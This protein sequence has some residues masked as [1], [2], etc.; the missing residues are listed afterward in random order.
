[1]TTPAAVQDRPMAGA[2]DD[3][4]FRLLHI[5]TVPMSLVFLRGQLAYMQARGADIHL[6]SSP[7]PALDS[8]AAEHGVPA[9][10]VVMNRRISPIADLAA[11]A[12]L[13]AVIRKLKPDIVHAHTPKAGLLGMIAAA[14]ERVPVRIYHMRGL[15]MLGRTGIQRKLLRLSERTACAAAHRVLCVSHSLREVALAERLC[16]P[17]HI[18]VLAGGSGN[19]VDAIGRFNPDTLPP[20][21]RRRV[22]ND[23]RIPEHA[24]VIGFVGRLVRD[25]GIAELAHAWEQV[26]SEHA[27]A[28]LMLV[29]PEEAGDAVPPQLL[30]QLRTDPRV[31]LVG[32]NWETPPLYAAMDL[33]VLPTYREGFPNVPLE[34]AA[35]RLP[36]IATRVPGCTDAVAD[37]KTGLLVEPRDAESLAEAMRVYLKD[38]ERRRTDGEAG[39]ALVLEHFAQEAIWAELFEEY[40][41][42]LRMRAAVS[43]A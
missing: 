43:G 7:G 42:Q 2:S 14:I 6:V 33:V 38:G 37:G 1:M 4:P 17:A 41:W 22:R 19:G 26:R 8:F 30:E 21:T 34:A 35:M 28:Y 29:G 5:T 9:T 20:D 16:A 25:K 12:E 24:R 10:P 39:R 3:R 23:L 27:G 18:K 13:T 31:R 36:V 15:P 40:H 11:L 32:E